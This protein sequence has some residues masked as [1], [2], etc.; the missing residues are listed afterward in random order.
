MCDASPF[1]MSRWPME[2]M[3]EER[4]VEPALLV[5]SALLIIVLITCCKVFQDRYC[6]LAY[7]TM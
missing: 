6:L 1:P 5:T 2:R 7:L 4:N 3:I